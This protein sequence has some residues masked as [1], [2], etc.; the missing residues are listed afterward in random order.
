MFVSLGKGTLAP[1]IT[2]RLGARKALGWLVG[3][4]WSQVWLVS[5]LATGNQQAN[6]ELF[7]HLAYRQLLRGGRSSLSLYRHPFI[8]L[9]VLA[10]GGLHEFQWD[11]GGKSSSERVGLAKGSESPGRGY[12]LKS[13]LREPTNRLSLLPRLHRALRDCSL[14]YSAALFAYI[15]VSTA[16]SWARSRNKRAEPTYFSTLLSYHF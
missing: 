13:R 3:F 14:R 7:V 6:Q 5:H 4:L 2:Y 8:S 15:G 11:R 12:P 9:A 10:A 1:P 16:N